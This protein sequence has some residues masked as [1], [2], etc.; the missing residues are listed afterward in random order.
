MGNKGVKCEMKKLN[1]FFFLTLFLKEEYLIKLMKIR[2]FGN[3]VLALVH[4]ARKSFKRPGSTSS[5]LNSLN[6]C[7]S[8]SH[9]KKLLIRRDQIWK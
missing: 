6:R 8:C 1:G 2:S 9:E 3:H 5:G 7:Q 4:C